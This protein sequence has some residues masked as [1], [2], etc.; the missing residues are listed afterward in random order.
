MSFINILANNQLLEDLEVRDNCLIGNSTTTKKLVINESI[1]LSE[2]GSFSG[3][4]IND[5]VES[6]DED[7]TE[8]IDLYEKILRIDNRINANSTAH[9]NN[10]GAIASRYTKTEADDKFAPKLNA[11]FTGDISIRENA[12]AQYETLNSKLASK[13]DS[14]TLATNHYTKTQM[15]TKLAD[16]ANTTDLDDYALKQNPSFKIIPD[17]RLDEEGNRVKHELECFS[18]NIDPIT[19]GTA[20]GSDPYPNGINST[21]KSILDDNYAPKDTTANG[22]T[23]LDDN[24]LDKTNPAIQTSATLTTDPLLTF[25]QV[26]AQGNQLE[27]KTLKQLLDAKEDSGATYTQQQIDSK[28]TDTTLTYTGDAYVTFIKDGVNTTLKSLLDEKL[29]TTNLPD[30]LTDYAPSANPNFTGNVIVNDNNIE[31]LINGKISGTDPSFTTTNDSLITFTGNQDTTLKALLNGKL[32]STALDNTV[33]TTNTITNPTFIGDISFKET[34]DD[35]AIELVGII[36]AKAPLNNANMTGNFK[37]NNYEVIYKPTDYGTNTLAQYIELKSPDISTLVPKPTDWTT[38]VSGNTNPSLSQYIGVKAPTTDISGKVDKPDDWTTAVSGNDNPSLSQY[39]GVKAP[40]TDISGK[41]DKPS[42]W[43][44][45]VSGNAD[46]SLSDYIGVKASKRLKYAIHIKQL[47]ATDSTEGYYWV[48]W[49]RTTNVIK[50]YNQ[51]G[52]IPYE[53]IHWVQWGNDDNTR[54]THIYIETEVPLSMLFCDFDKLHSFITDRPNPNTM[55]IELYVTNYDSIQEDLVTNYF[56]FDYSGLTYRKVYEY[57]SDFI[58]ACANTRENDGDDIDQLY[59]PIDYTDQLQMLFQKQSVTTLQSGMS[60]LVEQPSDW[61]PADNLQSYVSNKLSALVEQPSDWTT[62]DTLETYVDSKI[63]ESLAVGGTSVAV[64]RIYPPS[65]FPFDYTAN[66]TFRTWSKTDEAYGNGTYT[67]KLSSVLQWGYA[68]HDVS[69]VMD[70]GWMAVQPSGS[71]SGLHIPSG[72]QNWIEFKLPRA[73]QLKMYKITTRDYNDTPT[74]GYVGSAPRD[75]DMEGRNAWT[76]DSSWT[77]ID[78]RRDVKFYQNETQSFH[79]NDNAYLGMSTKSFN[80]FR[81][82][83]HR[84]QNTSAWLIMRELSFW[85]VEPGLDDI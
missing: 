51:V 60:A 83:I 42:D 50:I 55:K 3:K 54:S 63:S 1:T 18:I 72:T 6:L 61:T 69:S 19:A 81:L 67:L 40:T 52:Q 68:D 28:F 16:K 43:T 34:E 65:P 75:F 41:V 10:A 8:T 29:T 35:T 4:F 13:V 39:I 71:V 79:I 77:K 74:D 23:Q 49:M 15:N 66:E 20:G 12:D 26:D 27:A 44:T 11:Q 58:N 14:T 9:I 37:V 17:W 5:F 59:L 24:K 7:T 70:E 82:F 73:I 53:D 33:V 32:D 30:Q 62:S 31:T 25:K 48:M 47:D 36:N 2:T 57:S 46:P 45:A 22:I 21:L 85:G 84:N 78:V 76:G 38:A 80:E 64:P 56:S